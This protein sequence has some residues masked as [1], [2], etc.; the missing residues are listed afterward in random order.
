[1]DELKPC[2]K[3]GSNRVRV[4]GGTE[5]WHEYCGCCRVC[6]IEGPLM[7]GSAIVS[8]CGLFRY[9][10]GRA[11]GHANAA[12]VTWVMLN[13]ST[14]DAGSDDP[15]VR[16]VVGFSQRWGFGSANI[17]N[18]WPYRATSPKVLMAALRRYEVSRGVAELNLQYVRG[19]CRSADLVVAAWGGNAKPCP[20]LARVERTLTE[21]CRPVV[22]LGHTVSGQPRHPLMPAYATPKV[23]WRAPREETE[24]DG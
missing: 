7:S 1:M 6:D 20:D 24:I 18:V 4:L 17:V 19:T 23:P 15:T 3:C 5:D 2:P 21:C 11:W 14:A 13:P 12:S 8:D 10:L 22:C 9:V 16:K